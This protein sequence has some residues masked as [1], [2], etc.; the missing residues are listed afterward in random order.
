MASKTPRTD[1]A[2]TLM[3]HVYGVEVSFARQLEHELNQWQ[4]CADKMASCL[5]GESKI[6]DLDVLQ[7]YNQL[8]QK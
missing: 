5:R 6:P 1:A 8:K 2:V 4:S 7:I 3:C